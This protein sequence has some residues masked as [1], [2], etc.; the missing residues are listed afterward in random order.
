MIALSAIGMERT[1]LWIAKADG[2]GARMIT[3]EREAEF[4]SPAWTNDGEYVV[5]SRQA[6]GARTYELWMY[7]IHGGS[8]VQVT[9]SQIGTGPPV[10]P[11]PGGPPPPRFN[12]M[13]VTVSRDGKYFYYAKKTGGFAVQRYVSDVAGGAARPGERR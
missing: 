13:G 7:N 12:F 10:P 3:H 1:I 8:G 11:V 9:K 5:I 2:S 6:Q 4:A